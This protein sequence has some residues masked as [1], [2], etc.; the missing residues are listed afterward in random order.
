VLGGALA[1]RFFF[2]G[3]QEA[4]TGAGSSL[5][6]PESSSRDPESSSRGRFEDAPFGSRSIKSTEPVFVFDFP[7]ISPPSL[8]IS[9]HGSVLVLF[10]S[11]F[12]PVPLSLLFPSLKTVSLS[13]LNSLLISLFPLLII[14]GALEFPITLLSLE[15]QRRSAPASSGMRRVRLLRP[16]FS[17]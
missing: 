12:K 15:M 4:L 11:L 9:I 8:F 14:L 3:R 2:A 17:S 5:S 10:I 1:A 13:L 7:V 16:T 6:N